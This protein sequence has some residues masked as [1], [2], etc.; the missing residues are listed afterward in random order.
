MT[1]RLF[2]LVHGFRPRRQMGYDGAAERLQAPVFERQPCS[3]A[4][5]CAEAAGVARGTPP[6]GWFRRWT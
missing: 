1:L 4:S 2:A 5:F 6:G 3:R